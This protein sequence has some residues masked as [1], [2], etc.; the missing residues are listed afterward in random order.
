MLLKLII[1]AGGGLWPFRART[2]RARGP[3]KK[4]LASVY[5]GYLDGRGSYISLLAEFAGE[6]K[7]PHGA[8]GVF[9]S[10]R[11]KVGTGVTIM[12]QVTLGMILED[13][14]KHYG[15]PTIGNDVLLGPGAKVI[16]NAVIAD[17]ATIG[18]GAVVVDDV[19]SG[20]TVVTQAPR[21]ILRKE[22]AERPP[23]S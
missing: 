11:A 6:P 20:A 10:P 7:F 18:A 14:S 5:K 8:T 16:G 4:V 3:W 12:Q 22:S 9:V 1:K 19:P 13:G 23:A 17:G 21:V 2:I 15:G